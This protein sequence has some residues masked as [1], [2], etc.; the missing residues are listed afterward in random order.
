MELDPLP[1]AVLLQEVTP[2]TCSI[3]TKRLSANGYYAAPDCDIQ[4]QYFTITMLKR[5][6]MTQPAGYRVAYR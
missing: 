5:D 4:E 3:F 6:N 1:D 2:E